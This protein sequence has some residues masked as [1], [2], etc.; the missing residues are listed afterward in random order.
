[1]QCANTNRDCLDSRPAIHFGL[2]DSKEERETTREQ[3]ALLAMRATDRF[4]RKSNGSVQFQGLRVC[5]LWGVHK[6]A[7][8]VQAM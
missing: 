8:S 1:M 7:Q 4:D 3:T 5:G 2:F 6:Q